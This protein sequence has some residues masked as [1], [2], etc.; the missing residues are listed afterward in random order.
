M[1]KN[2]QGLSNVKHFIIQDKTSYMVHANNFCCF[3]IIFDLLCNINIIHQEHFHPRVVH[4]QCKK[5][6]FSILIF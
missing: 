4:I 5:N 6:N 2:K 1:T 3:L